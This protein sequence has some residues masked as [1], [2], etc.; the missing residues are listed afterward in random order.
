LG[1]TLA[2]TTTSITGR[3]F[4]RRNWRSIFI[5]IT[6]ACDIVIIG[7][8]GVV[9]LAV[10]NSI[11]DVAPIA[12]STVQWIGLLFAGTMVSYGLLLG[13]YRGAFRSNMRQQY[14]VAAKAY[15]YSIF[16][17]LLLFFAFQVDDLPPRLILLFLMVLPVFFVIGRTLLNGFNLYMQNRGFGVRNSLIL[18]YDRKGVEIFERFKGFP[19]LGYNVKA[20]AVV[21]DNHV[22]ENGTNIIRHN[23][24]EDLIPFLSREGIT[25]VFI[26]SVQLVTN[27]EA[28]LVDI[29]RKQKIKLKVLSPEADNLLRIARIHDIVGITL[30]SPSRE[31]IERIRN[32]VKRL[33]DIVGSSL[34]IL[35]ALP[36]FLLT[37]LAILIES[38]RPILFKQLRSATKNGKQFYFYKF[39]SMTRDADEEKED[40]YQFNEADGALFKLKN[41]PRLTRVG[42]LLRRFSI[43]E[44]PQLFNVLKGEMSLVGPRPL[45][46]ADFDRVNQAEEFWEAIRDREKV[47]PG[48]TGL[49][50]VSGRSNIGFKEMVLLDLYYVENRSLLLDLEILFATVPAV[51]YGKGAY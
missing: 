28:A 47:K 13:L 7:I 45:P 18:G 46:I 1:D 33:F 38:G 43:D 41:D 8:A 44:L 19:E 34:L 20:I 36:V 24:P 30:T 9:A 25:R 27:G 14:R 51:L 31:K 37:S 11:F 29:C 2:D 21:G 12:A 50:Q 16:T 40:L 5:L 6:I 49:W 48:I 23:K 17:L 15:G 3:K 32:R 10:R 35:L 42:K 39:R 22:K 4:A 26:P